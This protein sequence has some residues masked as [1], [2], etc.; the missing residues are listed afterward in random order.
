MYYVEKFYPIVLS[1]VFTF[2]VWKFNYYIIDFNILVPEIT[3][4]AMTIS[5]TLLG[6]LLTIYTIINSINTRRMQFVKD[7]GNFERLISFLNAPIY[8]NII[9]TIAAFV[10]SFINRSQVENR[11]LMTIDIIFIFITIFSIL[12]SVRFA[13]IF[14]RLLADKKTK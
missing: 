9:V 12:L 10:I 5:A 3:Q 14:I 8:T 11:L 6:F 7:S 2:L 1:A 13:M 4:S